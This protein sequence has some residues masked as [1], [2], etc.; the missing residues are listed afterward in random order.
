MKKIRLDLIQVL[1]FIFLLVGATFFV[2]ACYELNRIHWEPTSRLLDAEGIAF[3]GSP[4]I[5]DV[6]YMHMMVVASEAE[7]H[8]QFSV[9]IQV[10]FSVDPSMEGSKLF[11][12][13][14]ITYNFSHLTLNGDIHSDEGSSQFPNQP[15][16][17]EIVKGNSFFWTTLTLDPH[18]KHNLSANIKMDFTWIDCVDR[19]S[20]SEFRIVIP[21]ALT[22]SRYR[23]LPAV[24][25]LEKVRGISAYQTQMA[26]LSLNLSSSAFSLSATN[27]MADR[28]TFGSS[29]FWFLWDVKS[30]CTEKVDS[31]AFAADFVSNRLKRKESEGTY[32]SALFF[33]IGIPLMISSGFEMV[34]RVERTPFKPPKL[35]KC[36]KC[37][38]EFFQKRWFERCPRCKGRA[39]GAKNR[40]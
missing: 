9:E 18:L 32:W 36:L 5:S 26:S 28:Y 24:I 25:E 11:F 38:A 15:Y 2:C 37:G 17:K 12:G 30:R 7:E 29:T 19:R 31:I 8:P 33:G 6:N 14:Q 3:F 4:V 13:A 21:F 22:P 27:P 20:F 23:R 10:D 1:F 39:K 34:R 40:T 16:E 35:M